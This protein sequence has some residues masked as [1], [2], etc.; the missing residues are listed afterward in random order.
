MGWQRPGLRRGL[1]NSQKT[2]VAYTSV[3]WSSAMAV[4]RLTAPCEHAGI[5]LIQGN[6]G[7]RI[8]I[9]LVSQADVVV[10]QRDFP[11]FYQQTRQIIRRAH[12]QKIPVLYEADDLLLETPEIHANYEHY[13]GALLTILQTVI[14]VDAVTVSTSSLQEYFKRLNP[15]TW[16]L[17]NCLVDSLWPFPPEPPGDDL[18]VVIGYMGGETHR[19]DLEMITPALKSLEQS[20]GARLTFRFWGGR[21]PDELLNSPRTE[22]IA[23]NN[24][25][26][27]QF[28][29]FFAAQKA[30][31]FISPLQ[32]TL[33][34]RCKSG[35][36]FL[37]YSVHGAPG[38]YSKLPPYQEL[39]CHAENGFLAGSLDEW[40][41]YLRLLIEDAQLR[42][43]VGRRA[44]QTVQDNWL[45]S[46]H[47]AEWRRVYEIVKAQPETEAAWRYPLGGILSRIDK[48]YQVVETRFHQAA[49]MV[50]DRDRTIQQK[51][52]ELQA[53]EDQLQVQNTRINQQEAVIQ[54][55]QE[56]IQ[57]MHERISEAVQQVAESDRQL[58]AAQNQLEAIWSSQ[59]WKLLQA[60]LKPWRIV[61]GVL[62]KLRTTK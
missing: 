29:D 43:Q 59:S 37:E 36:K 10:I 55:R 56:Q 5:K 12:E 32:D 61:S 18:P 19:L 57:E 4:L 47:R 48:Y 7:D 40:E 53:K 38:V 45:L 52:I 42:E 23:Y 21:P 33:F 8:K 34:N 28:A 51:D 27:A 58:A 20:Y 6:Q 35:I 60:F 46:Q 25:H 2:I 17:P 50:I 14:E 44:Q 9:D 11:R 41:Q 49:G 22:W 62:R 24:D 16:V 13:Q 54:A 1:E 3:P 30:H 15:N 31:I 39:V 26:Y